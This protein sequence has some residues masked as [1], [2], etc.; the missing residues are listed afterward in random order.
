MSWSDVAAVE[1]DGVSFGPHSRSHPI[2]ARCD[3]ALVIDEV[4]GSC[5]D[6]GSRLDSP[7]PAFAFPNGDPTSFGERELS[8]LADHGVLVSLTTTGGYLKQES[9]RSGRFVLPRFSFPANESYFRMMMN[10]TVR[11]NGSSTV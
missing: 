9:D 3:Q 4:V 10:G 2:L 5:K 7:C 6:L 8:L 1:G 11:R